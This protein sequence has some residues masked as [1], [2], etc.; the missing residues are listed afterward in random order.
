MAAITF[1]VAR[2][3]PFHVRDLAVAVRYFPSEFRRVRDVRKGCMPGRPNLSAPLRLRPMLLDALWN[4]ERK[5]VIDARLPHVRAGLDDEGFVFRV[6]RLRFV[7][8]ALNEAPYR[9]CKV[10][11]VCHVGNAP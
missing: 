9:R 11:F 6:G 1:A 3:F 10:G 2:L 5:V 8:R 4:G 7:E